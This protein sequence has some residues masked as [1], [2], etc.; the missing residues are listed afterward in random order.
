MPDPALRPGGG[1]AGHA[2]DGCRAFRPAAPDARA[3]ACGGRGAPVRGGRREKSRPA[4]SPGAGAK[5]CGMA[6]GRSRAVSGRLAVQFAFGAGMGR[7]RTAPMPR[8]G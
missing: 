3:T 8:R 4:A 7:K 1:T 5:L 2:R 6:V